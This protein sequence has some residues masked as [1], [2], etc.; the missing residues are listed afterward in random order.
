MPTG[1]ERYIA[2]AVPAH[3]LLTSLI[4]SPRTVLTNDPLP[5]ANAETPLREPPPD[6]GRRDGGGSS[7]AGSKGPDA[8]AAS[9]ADSDSQP[10]F[11][12]RALSMAQRLK[13]QRRGKRAPTRQRLLRAEAADLCT[14][15]SHIAA[16]IE[17][18]TPG[19]ALL[20]VQAS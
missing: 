9:N 4:A 5:F 15:Q 10:D 18:D 13:I 8:D 12:D 1:S 7:S 6:L 17:V 3:V 20:H 16:L 19:P 11:L 14:I 2:A